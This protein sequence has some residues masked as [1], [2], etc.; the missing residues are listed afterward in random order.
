MSVIYRILKTKSIVEY[1]EKKGHRPV[2]HMQSGCLLY[3]CPFPDHKE[4]KPSFVVWTQAE[5]ENFRCFGCQ[6]NYNIINLISELEKISFKEAVRLLSAGMEVGIDEDVEFQL[7]MIHKKHPIKECQLGF[8][9]A[10][11]SLSSMCRAYLLGVENHPDELRII[12]MFWREVDSALLE[13]KFDEFEQMTYH[14]PKILK[15]RR[16]KFE[17]SKIDRLRSTNENPRVY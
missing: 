16:E 10:L 3:L 15:T 4:K 12:D 13:C 7:E 11:F 17:R 14:L 2:K 6:R 1:L 8:S 9:Q 5:Y